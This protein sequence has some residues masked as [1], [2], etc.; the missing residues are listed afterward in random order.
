MEDAQQTGTING[1]CDIGATTAGLWLLGDKE[2]LSGDTNECKITGVLVWGIFDA[3]RSESRAC[4]NCSG[5]RQESI[6]RDCSPSY[7]R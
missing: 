3:L 1:N 6:Q 7:G 5:Y 4:P 2:G